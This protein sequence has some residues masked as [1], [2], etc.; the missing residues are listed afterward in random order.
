MAPY[1]AIEGNDVA[2][3]VHEVGE[4]VTKFKKGDKVGPR[5]RCDAFVCVARAA[6]RVTSGPKSAQS[7]RVYSC[8][9]WLLLP[10]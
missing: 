8:H 5:S 4:G 7:D 10:E 1:E 9:R 3:H 6:A 2:G